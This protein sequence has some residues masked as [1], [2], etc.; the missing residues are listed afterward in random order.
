MR[1]L[2]ITFLFLPFSSIS[3]HLSYNQYELLHIEELKNGPTNIDNLY[4]DIKGDAFFHPQWLSAIA[5]A[6]NGKTYKGIKVKFDQYKNKFYAN[7]HDTIYDMSTTP[8]SRY[9]LYPSLIDTTVS[10]TFQKG[11]SGNGLQPAAYIRVLASGRLTFVKYHTLE[12]KD[13][14]EDGFL[15][16]VK[17]FV[18]QDYY[19]LIRD[20]S[21]PSM[22]RINKKTLEKEM[23]DKWKEISGQAKEKEVSFN[24]EEGWKYLVSY[25]NTLP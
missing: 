25:Y 21:Q 9:I 8:I 23:A 19:Y 2:A 16:T 11:F 6:E 20:N 4:Q 14:H 12:I 3:Q 10:Y 22:V 15:T 5:I 17:T 1:F 13:S 7:I 18:P 24:E